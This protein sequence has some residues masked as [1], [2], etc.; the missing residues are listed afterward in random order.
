MNPQKVAFHQR[1]HHASHKKMCLFRVDPFFSDFYILFGSKKCMIY[2]QFISLV[3]F[4]A[5]SCQS[6]ISFFFFFVVVPVLGANAA[7]HR[8]MGLPQ[9]AGCS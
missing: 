9:G 6:G 7:T 3:N 2:R 8:L 5:V 4:F 1:F